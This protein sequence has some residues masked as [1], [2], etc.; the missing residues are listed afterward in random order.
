MRHQHLCCLAYHILLHC[1]LRSRFL[2]ALFFHSGVTVS[3]SFSLWHYVGVLV[4]RRLL[5]MTG[6]GRGSGAFG[7]DRRIPFSN[8]TQYRYKLVP[9][10][11]LFPYPICWRR[12][13]PF[14]GVNSPLD[15]F[16]LPKPPYHLL[17]QHSL[18]HGFL[19]STLGI[20][21]S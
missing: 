5:G 15:F 14:C 1:S 6:G 2:A 7:R 10:F 12:S 4:K 3:T 18:F 16:S 11:Y 17:S 20:A 19:L 13:S 21:P 8:T 9:G